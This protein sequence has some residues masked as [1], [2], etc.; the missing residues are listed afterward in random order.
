M[1]KAVLIVIA[2]LLFFCSQ[3]QAVII[4]SINANHLDTIFQNVGGNYNIGLLNISDKADIV[5]EYESGEQTT[6]PGGSLALTT[7]LKTDTS[8]NGIA[9]GYFEAGVL[10]ILDGKSDTLLS[11]NIDYLNLSEIMDG[12][13]LIAGN[14]LFEVT[15]GSLENDFDYH[16][17]EIVYL[18]F[19]VI[20]KDFIDLSSNFT[21]YTDI[22]FYPV[23][24]PAT[25]CLLGL[26]VLGLL[27]E[28][29]A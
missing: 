14:G 20:P 27:R 5:V 4:S 6:F 16:I 29:R 22:T 8:Y 26:G 2:I 12:S 15:G 13:G 25:I 28:R 19:K 10:S 11:G 18:T 17:G 23:P 9:G 3:S 1:R 21:G 24:E 7:S